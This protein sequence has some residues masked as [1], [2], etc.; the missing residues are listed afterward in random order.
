MH[1]RLNVPNQ[2]VYLR[3][4]FILFYCIVKS[5]RNPLLASCTLQ[6]VKVQGK[7]EIKLQ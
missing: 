4:Y 1:D 2:H 6:K 7:K 5:R 3:F